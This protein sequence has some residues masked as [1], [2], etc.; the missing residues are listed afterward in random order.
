[1]TRGP[2]SAV[3]EFED[4]RRADRRAA[5][6]HDIGHVFITRAAA[7]VI[8]PG[9]SPILPPLVALIAK[10]TASDQRTEHRYGGVVVVVVPTPTALVV[11]RQ[12]EH[13]GAAA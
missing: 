12:G 1:M 2:A 8:A 3:F 5:P 7:D 10:H 13:I 9:G 4:D 11:G 6:G